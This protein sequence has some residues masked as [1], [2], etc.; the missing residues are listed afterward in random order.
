VSERTIKIGRFSG[1]EINVGKFKVM[2]IS[3]QPSPIQIIRDQKQLEN[4][5]YF[6]CLSSMLTNDGT[7]AREINKELP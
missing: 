7:C 6:D 1:M 5:V 2:R 4:V 3:R